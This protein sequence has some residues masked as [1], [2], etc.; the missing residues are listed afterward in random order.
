MLVLSLN[1]SHI[2][3]WRAA[4]DLK[5]IDSLWFIADLFHYSHVLFIMHTL[6]VAAK[7]QN[8]SKTLTLP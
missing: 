1:L 3:L 7:R 5:F 2:L 6:I 8:Y 4:R